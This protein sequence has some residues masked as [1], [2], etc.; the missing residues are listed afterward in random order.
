MR[1]PSCLSLIAG[2]LLASCATTPA[3]PPK[4]AP[5]STDALVPRAEVAPPKLRLPTTVQPREYRLSMRFDPRAP[6]YE[7]RVEIDVELAQA[8]DVLWLHAVR[9]ETTQAQLRAKTGETLPLEVLAKHAPF[10]GLR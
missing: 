7:G 10:L 1:S 8:T 9:V 5:P 6:T 4:P 3:A 2:A